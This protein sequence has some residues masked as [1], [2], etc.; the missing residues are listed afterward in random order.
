[1]PLQSK[2]LVRLQAISGKRKSAATC[3]GDAGKPAVEMPGFRVTSLG[4]NPFRKKGFGHFA[5]GLPP[6][7]P[8]F[9]EASVLSIATACLR[10]SFSS[11]MVFR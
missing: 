8:I 7:R 6:I 9:F 2:N 10:H 1:M 5:V 3:V 11:S 4:G